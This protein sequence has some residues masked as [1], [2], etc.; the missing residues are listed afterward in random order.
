VNVKIEDA[1]KADA[2]FTKLMGDEVELRKNFIQSRA[3]T[4][5]L[6]DLDF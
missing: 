3:K 2:I 6:D 1:E 4:V 5:N